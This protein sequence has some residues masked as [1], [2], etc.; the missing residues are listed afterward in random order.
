MQARTPADYAWIT[1]RVVT[2]LWFAWLGAI[3]LFVHGP[4]AFAKQVAEFRILMDPWNLPVAYLVPWLELIAGLLLLGHFWPRG[5]VR[6]LGLLTL[7]F[8]FAN[9]QALYLGFEPDCG[10][11]G[12]AFKLGLVPKLWLIGAQFAILTTIL[13]G[14]SRARRGV[15]AGRRMRLPG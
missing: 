10:C 7:V 12:S 5:A 15:F 6:V 8:L 3:K 4:P 2:G 11:F 9:A 14:E 13:I 1:L